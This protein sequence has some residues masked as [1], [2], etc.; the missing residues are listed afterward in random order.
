[1]GGNHN[2]EEVFWEFDKV[3]IQNL[4]YIFYC[5]G[6]NMAVLSPWFE[7]SLNFSSRLLKSLN[8]VKSLKST[9]FLYEVLKSP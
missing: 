1:M 8:L 6:T 4:S 2:G 5:F 7:K 9:R 3:I